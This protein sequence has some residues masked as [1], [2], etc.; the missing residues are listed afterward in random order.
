MRDF[1]VGGA[2]DAS[3]VLM[4]HY[5]H[6]HAHPELSYHE[7][8]TARYVA[9][10][11]GRLNLD[12]IKT[13]VGGH[14][15]T[16]LLAGQSGGPVIGLRADM[17][18]LSITETTGCP[19]A[20]QNPGV[21]HA[22]GH[23]GHTAILLTVAQILAAHRDKL[24]G[25]VKFLFQ[26]SEECTPLGGSQ[27]MI[28]DGALENP[29]VD[30]ILGLHLWPTLPC[31]S[32]GLQAGAV[33]AASDHLNITVLGKSC[34]ASMPD[35]GIDAIV[36]ASNVVM[37]LQTV[38]SRNVPPAQ[39]AV[40]TIGTMSGGTRYN[41]LAD[42]VEMEG[43]VR[44][45]DEGVHDHLPG[46]IVRTAENAAKALGATAQVKYERGYPPTV[47]DR[48]LVELLEPVASDVTGG[49]L[50]TG[51]PV[52]PTGEDFAFFAKA[53]PSAFAWLGCRPD[54][55]SP[56]DMPP[57]H[58]SS[59]LPASDSLKLGVLYTCHAALALMSAPKEAF[60]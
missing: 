25:T 28:R 51:L 16:A 33:S 32:I 60:A 9:Q 52:P 19:F 6:L 45:F 47:N 10:V 42:R 26:P 36:A 3:S 15:V 59:F 30:A 8:E 58:N 38:V 18:A 49:K 35:G 27:L 55:V 14:G 54:G 4:E 34:H 2:N 40:V 31:G 57:L 44:S 22:C 43:T 53:R 37:A 5:R 13:G 39:A 23:D 56:E 29:H 24:P 7:E 17:D 46:W 20:S 1:F 41:I 48:R 11:L 21:M 50:L 12:E